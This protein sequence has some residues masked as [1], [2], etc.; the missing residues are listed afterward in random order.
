MGIYLI[1]QA[2]PAARV[3]VAHESF[4]GRSAVWA[5]PMQVARVRLLGPDATR[6]SGTSVSID[7]TTAGIGVAVNGQFMA[8]A[9]GVPPRGRPV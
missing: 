4:V 7:R 9:R 3:P 2:P 6:G 8:D 1:S 5:P